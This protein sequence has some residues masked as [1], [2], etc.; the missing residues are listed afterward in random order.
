VNFDDFFGQATEGRSPYEFQREFAMGESLPDL[1]AVPTGAGKTATAVLGWLYRRR[2]LRRPDTG[3]RLVYCLPMRSLVDQTV[4]EAA[5]WLRR[6]GLNEEIR[7]HALLGGAVDQAWEESVDAEAILV[8]TQDQLLSRALNRGYA[9]SRYRWPVHF[10]LLHNDATWVI[11]EVQLLGVGVSTAVQLQGLRDAWGTA[12]PARTVWMS[13]TLSPTRL[14]TV[15]SPFPRRE[16]VR[17]GLCAEDR[18]ESSPLHP[19]LTARK[20][21][22]PATPAVVKKSDDYAKILAREVLTA[23]VEGTRTLV[24]LNRVP[25]AQ[26]LA[27]AL[28]KLGDTPVALVHSRF[29]PVDRARAQHAA[30]EPAWTG[31]LVSTQAIEAG[32]DISSRTLFTEVAPWSSLVQ[33]FGRCN[34]AG[35]WPEAD[36][37]W[38]DMPDDAELALPYLPAQLTVA[39]ERLRALNDVGPNAIAAIPADEGEVV[40]P[41]IRRRDLLHLFDTEP[42]LAGHDIDVSRFVRGSEDRDVAVA[43]RSLGAEAPPADAPALRREELVNVPAHAVKKLLEKRDKD[44]QGWRWDG[45]DGRWVEVD[46]RRLYPGMTV[47]LPVAAGGYDADLGW[48]GVPSDR[49]QPVHVSGP[50][51]DEDDRDPLAVGCNRYVTLLQ[52]AEDVAEELSRMR[53]VGG[54]VPWDEIGVAARWHDLGKVHPVFQEMLTANLEEGDERRFTGPWAKSDGVH[55]GRSQRRGFR[56]ELASALGWLAQGGGDL[57]AYLI[58]AHHGKVRTSLRARPGEPRGRKEG[59]P[60]PVRFAHGVWEGDE[61]PAQDLGGGTRFAG[62]RLT[63]A[64]MEM[65]AVD[66]SAP[67]SDRVIGLLERYGPFRLAFYESLVRIADWRGS[68]KWTGVSDG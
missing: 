43:W 67:W 41:V 29:R 8:G 64:V 62:A 57:E 66:G 9:M 42:D 6:L 47:L 19:R 48:T 16:P 39:R 49:P 4:R 50:P 65:G 2:H 51:N 23:H 17:L 44:I 61:L 14:E 11:D 34:R 60:V 38:I 53:P 28:R 45:G 33:R 18:E 46:P 1:L 58:A 5:G 3:R 12:L 55:S 21:L 22:V 54:D 52:H 37:R 26:A 56:H 68:R 31:I 40:L 24:V 27:A 36:V 10:A 63:L 25:R 13:A 30:L 35:E 7:V 32:V 15:D 20:V 59:E